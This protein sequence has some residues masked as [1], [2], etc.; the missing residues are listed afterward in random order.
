MLD[1][2]VVSMD[3]KA[4]IKRTAPLAV[5]R[6]GLAAIRHLFSIRDIRQVIYYCRVYGFRDGLKT[7][8]RKLHLKPENKSLSF[9]KIVV[10][11]GESSFA[12]EKKV[13]AVIPTKNAGADFSSLLKML[14]LQ[15]GFNDIEIIIVDSGSTDET[16]TIAGNE[17]AK[18]LE[19]PP[20]DFHHAHSRN[21]GAESASG[22]YILFLVQD[23]LPSSDHWLWEMARVF[24]SNDVV[25]VSCA[26]HPRPDCDLFYRSLMWNHYRAL[27]LD[28]DRL[29]G[30]DES[31]AS[32][33]GLRAN[34]QIS[35]VALLVKR[36]IFLGY[37]FKGKFM[38]DLEL[39]IRLI[40]DGHRMGFLHSTR[41]IHSHNRPAYY[42]LKRAY[43]EAK[44]WMDIFP[45]FHFPPI[46][47]RQRL[48]H[49]IA[50]LYYKTRQVASSVIEAEVKSGEEL[51]RFMDRVKLQFLIDHSMAEKS[52]AGITNSDLESFVQKL[53]SVNGRQVFY[54]HSD[55]MLRLPLVNNLE[56]V[57]AYL[58]QNRETADRN[59]AQEL[60]EAL[61]KMMALNSGTHLAYLYLTLSK[62]GKSDLFSPE[63]DAALCSGI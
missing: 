23:A 44:C 16:L 13:S 60:G 9:T 25:A 24:E 50:A 35:N 27:Y 14:K 54:K 45:D 38:E 56:Q 30:W 10:P 18:I 48:F 28:R 61:P 49:D 26:E 2:A 40:R 53:I 58:S 21:R 51:N 41:I 43:V 8:V 12:F 62:L 31:C 32:N 11:D 1:S 34:S 7:I 36:D 52:V 19:I 29:L 39:G 63:L 20:E 6:F 42:Y 5:L 4:V 57:L 55:N 17:G 46:G 33:F 15:K 47:S 59:L 22:D 37:R 3:K